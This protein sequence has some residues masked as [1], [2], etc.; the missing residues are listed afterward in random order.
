V[1]PDTHITCEN[2]TTTTTLS[3]VGR[4]FSKRTLVDCTQSNLVQKFN[5]W[6][7]ISFVSRCRYTVICFRMKCL[8]TIEWL[9]DYAVKYLDMTK[10]SVFLKEF[11]CWIGHDVRK[12][13]KF[14][15]ESGTNPVTFGV[16]FA[17]RS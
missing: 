7:S 16:A 13:R 4:T 3:C 10:Q 14:E 6:K 11:V 17:E 8:F 2:A 1:T 12:A 9:L 5:R 15:L